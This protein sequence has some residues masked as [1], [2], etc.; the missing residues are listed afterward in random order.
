[1]ATAEL[2]GLQ[3][4]ND[5]IQPDDVQTFGPELEPRYTDEGAIKLVTED[6]YRA[7]NFIDLKQW[8]LH[9]R[10][11]DVLYQSPRTTAQFEAA[12]WR[13]RTFHASR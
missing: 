6:A 4:A 12:P 2:P 8:N 10:E 9:W 7:Q 13:G 11:S 3:P 5:R 1:M